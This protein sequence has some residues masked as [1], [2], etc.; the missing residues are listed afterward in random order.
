MATVSGTISGVAGI[1]RFGQDQSAHR[2]G[3][4]I[5]GPARQKRTELFLS[6]IIQ[7]IKEK[8]MFSR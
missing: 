6:A 5:H 8:E 4:I 2:V 3:Q 1:G 7:K